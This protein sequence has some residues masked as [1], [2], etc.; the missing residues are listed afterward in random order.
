MTEGQCPVC[1]CRR[2]YVKDPDDPYEQ[3]ALEIMD[4][5]A[6]FEGDAPAAHGRPALGADTELFCDRCSWHD[7]L[8]TLTRKKGD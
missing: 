5:Q 3:Y 2:F 6:C 1:G 8:Q 4:G 7:R